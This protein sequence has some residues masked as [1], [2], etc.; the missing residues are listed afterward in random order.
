MSEQIEV[1]VASYGYDFGAIRMN[2]ETA[3]KYAE[4]LVG[5]EVADLLPGSIG[6]QLRVQG[7]VPIRMLRVLSTRLEDDPTNPLQGKVIAICQ[8][9]RRPGPQEVK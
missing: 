2:K 9:I 8:E 5:Q 4:Q 6:A 3:Q 1:Q 7:F